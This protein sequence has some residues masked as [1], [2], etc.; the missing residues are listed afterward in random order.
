MKRTIQHLS[1]VKT[2]LMDSGPLKESR[3]TLVDPT[4]SITVVFWS[5]WMESVEN[6]KS[7]IFTNLR[8]KNIY[9]NELYVNTAKV[10]FELQETS[11]FTDP[12]PYLS[13]S[14]M[15]L[16]TKTVGITII[17]IK[18]THVHYSWT[19]CKK[20]AEICGKKSSS[21]RI[22]DY[23][24]TLHLTARN[25]SLRCVFKTK[26]SKRHSTSRHSTMK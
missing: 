24:R 22:V 10:G 5:D 3:A 17:G 26:P 12:L 6:V 25:G 15:D 1:S 13:P 20:E 4:G 19:A 18:N 23:A 7:Y 21:I 14:L 9:T 2:V 8:I 11:P 16:T